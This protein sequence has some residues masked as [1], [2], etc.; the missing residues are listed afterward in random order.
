[1]EAIE[2]GL[3]AWHEQLDAIVT[4]LAR[5]L[6]GPAMAESMAELVGAFAERVVKANPDASKEA[7]NRK[8]LGLLMAV[9]GRIV[10]Q[11]LV[12]ASASGDAMQVDAL[13]ACVD[14]LVDA[15]RSA[16]SNVNQKLVLANLVAQCAPLL[17]GRGS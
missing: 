9:V 1:L 14:A 4:D 17:S 2:H 12:A 10:Q 6:V 7:A 8:A 5:G 11:R 15:E 3:H 13:G 16:A